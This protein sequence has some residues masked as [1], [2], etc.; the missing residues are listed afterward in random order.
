LPTLPDRFRSRAVFSDVP[1]DSRIVLDSQSDEA[2]ARIARQA[3]ERE[4][5]FVR[6]GQEH[7]QSYT[8]GGTS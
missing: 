4:M 6:S 7:S 5:A 3:L 1:E 8:G 2:L